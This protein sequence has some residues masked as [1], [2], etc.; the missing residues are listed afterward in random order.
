[1][2]ETTETP[3]IGHNG[4]PEIEG[5]RQ[6][7][8]SL[9]ELL[10]QAYD[11]DVAEPAT[12]AQRDER[13]RFAATEPKEQEPDPKPETDAVERPEAWSEA[14]WTGL[15]PDV[16]R[17]IAR[18]EKDHL[19]ALTARAEESNEATAYKQVIAPYADRFA[20][21]GLTPHQGIQRLL[22]WEKSLTANPVSAL[23]QLAQLYGVD[24]GT[25][26]SSTTQQQAPLRDPRVDQLLAERE[27]D[28]AAAQA[29]ET[30]AIDA[31]IAA[32]KADSRNPHFEQVRLV[33]AG[34]MQADTNLTMREAY[35]RA[36]WADPKL[37]AEQQ[38]KAAKEAETERKAKEAEK[39]KAARQASV[40]VRDNS[41]VGYVNGKTYAN[42]TTRETLL[43][44]WDEVANA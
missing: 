13:G 43:R 3:G 23:A 24:L 4:G 31:Q 17:A 40:S 44:S 35:D 25:L 7:P 26:T 36:I 29:R 32:F 18:R 12:E 5:Q 9:R 22:E 33:M 14:E 42:E 6:E 8:P 30:A 41:P 21:H 39:V 34:M 16:Q 10:S 11:A 37:R 1:M 20:S 2:S 19:E 27:R 38:A 15:N 28:K